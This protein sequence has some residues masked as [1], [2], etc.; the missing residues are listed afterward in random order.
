MEAREDLGSVAGFS[1]ALECWGDLG[2]TRWPGYPGCLKEPSLA[3]GAQ[4]R[5]GW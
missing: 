2:E 4:G 3:G 5:V 1:R